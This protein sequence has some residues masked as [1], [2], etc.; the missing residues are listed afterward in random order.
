MK[1]V[2]STVCMI[3]VGLGLVSASFG[4][5]INDV[6]QPLTATDV[7][8]LNASLPPTDP[9]SAQ[10]G[11][12]APAWFHPL[13]GE[14]PL[15]F[16]SGTAAGFYSGPGYEWKYRNSATFPIESVLLVFS[17]KTALTEGSQISFVLNGLGGG[18]FSQDF[19]A[20]DFFSS[21]AAGF[22]SPV[23]GLGNG[24]ATLGIDFA[25]AYHAAVQ[26]DVDLGAHGEQLGSLLVSTPVDVRVDIFGMAQL[27]LATPV[28]PK[29]AIGKNGVTIPLPV[30]TTV[31]RI[32]N[33]SPNSGSV[34]F[35]QTSDNNPPTRVPD[36]GTTAMLLGCSM[37]MM[38]GV[39]YRR[40][41]CG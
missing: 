32:V 2:K 40:R 27:P 15:V 11:P 31:Y 16:D 13:S 36:G 26:V 18:T 6:S 14:G 41:C 19:T 8:Y 12:P 10:Y 35:R 38:A 3:A 25:T 17:P 29:V 4:L 5:P 24:T 33:N 28:S 39:A 22:P 23:S 30:P 20:G 34:G 21:G 9:L 1:A 37:M 7:Q